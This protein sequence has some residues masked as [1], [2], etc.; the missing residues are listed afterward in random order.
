MSGRRRPHD[1]GTRAEWR[2]AS[3]SAFRLLQQD[4]TLLLDSDLEL[5]GEDREHPGQCHL[6][7]DQ[8]LLDLDAAMDG[9]AESADTEMQGIALPAFLDE[10]HPDHAE[11]IADLVDAAA[12][13]GE[14]GIPAEIMGDGDGNGL[15]HVN[16]SER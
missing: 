13:A 1:S 12:Q 15:T 14:R 8:P 5:L 10:L 16:S 6:D 11:P 3:D 2:A 4:L 9:V 7:A